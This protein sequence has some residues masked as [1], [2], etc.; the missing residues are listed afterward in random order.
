MKRATMKSAAVALGFALAASGANA[1]LI[2]GG[3]SFSDGLS[4]LSSTPG[5]AVS[6]LTYFDFFNNFAFQS[7]EYGDYADGDTGAAVA[8]DLDLNNLGTAVWVSDDGF[9]FTPTSYNNLTASIIGCAPGICTDLISFT[10]AG[11]VSAPG[12]DDTPFA[13]SFTAQGT[14]TAGGKT[15]SWSASLASVVPVPAA[16]PLLAS[17]LV[18]L[19]VIARRRKALAA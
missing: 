2:Q 19:G 3:I 13:G 9:T 18:G 8:N 15:G 17:G 6:D 4:T 7:N 14:I 11:I 5:R 1:A 16:L 10:L 12:F